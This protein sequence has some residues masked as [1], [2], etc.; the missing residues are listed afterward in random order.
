MNELLLTPEEIKK[1]ECVYLTINY[2][3]PTKLRGKARDNALLKAQVLKCQEAKLDRP[4][5]EKILKIERCET[6]VECPTEYSD[7]PCAECRADQLLALNILTPEVV[8]GMVQEAK[9]LGAKEERE[10]IQKLMK[11]VREG[12]VMLNCSAWE[13][14]WNYIWQALKS[15][16]K[17][18]E[19]TEKGKE[20]SKV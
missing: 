14:C 8:D 15:K 1:Y 20:V 12:R 11:G 19:E 10:R 18:N 2:P 7:D 17:V 13:M 6:D 3:F 4:D 9:F 16:E 5:R